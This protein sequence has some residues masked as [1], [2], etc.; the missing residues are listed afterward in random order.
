MLLFI[1]ERPEGL[2]ENSGKTLA[3]VVYL[4]SVIYQLIVIC[5]NLNEFEIGL[6]VPIHS[7]SYSEE[8]ET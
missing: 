6:F 5:K 2:G 7:G 8:Y 1:L 4:S 3:W